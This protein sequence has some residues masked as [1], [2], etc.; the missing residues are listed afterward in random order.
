M[1]R[2]PMSV[3]ISVTYFYIYYIFYCVYIKNCEYY[4]ILLLTIFIFEGQSSENVYFYIYINFLMLF[5]RIF[6][7]N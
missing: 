7:L 5:K 1:F 4:L 2:S 3:L 6:L